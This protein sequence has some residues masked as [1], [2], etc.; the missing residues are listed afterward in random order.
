[1]IDKSWFDTT[2]FTENDG[3]IKTINALPNQTHVDFAMPILFVTE[4]GYLFKGL[5]FFNQH[6]INGFYEK[7]FHWEMLWVADTEEVFH[8][9]QITHWRYCAPLPK[10]YSSKPAIFGYTFH[11][12]DVCTTKCGECNGPCKMDGND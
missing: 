11:Y 9:S 5:Y 12:Q 8:G 1:M 6:P 10:K 3:W 2:A 4:D 7:D